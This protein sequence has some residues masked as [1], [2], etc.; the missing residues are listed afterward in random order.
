MLGKS[1]W[2][3]SPDYTDDSVQTFK[4]DFKAPDMK[5]ATLYISAMGV[6]APYLNG[7]RVGRNV[8]A[9]G[10]TS[11]KKRVQ[12]QQYDVTDMLKGENILEIGVGVGWTSGMGWVGKHFYRERPAVIAY[13]EMTDT[14]G[15]M[16]TLCTD[17]SWQVWAGNVIQSTIYHG[18]TVDMT[19][20]PKFLC[21]AEETEVASALVAQTGED[22]TEHERIYPVEVIHTPKGELV[23]DFGQNMTGYVEMKI[24]GE[25]GTK[26]V[27]HHAEV[28]DRD[29]NFYTGNYRHAKNENIYILS[30]N[31][32]VFKPTYTFQGFRY[33]RLTG[34]PHEKVNTMDF[35]AIA[36]HSE[37]KR[38]GY[39]KCGNEKINQ[40]YHNI[41]WGH[42]S[43]YLDVPTDCP[44]RDERLG[45]TCDTHVFC[46]T[47][48]I[49]YDVQKFLTKWMED[50]AL[51]QLENG[52]IR[53]IVP[54]CLTADQSRPQCPISG[55][56]GD[57][58]CIVPW[59]M[60]L[61]Y[62]DKN[63]LRQFLPAMKKWV[64]YEHSTDPE[65]FLYLGG[66]HY[67]DWLA[68]DHDP[69][70]LHGATS[71]DLLA[72]AYFA[73]STSLVVKAG[74]IIGEDVEEYKQL[75]KKVVAKFRE[76]FME[77]GMPK[78]SFPHT[79]TAVPPRDIARK[80]VTQ[81]ALTLILRFN[82]CTDEER[83]ALVKKLVELIHDFG[84]M[85]STGFV[86]TPHILHALSENG[87]TGL[88]YTLFFNEK[89]PSWLYSV[90]HGATTMW[91]H[92]NSLKEDGTFWSDS[93]NSFNHY[94][95]GAV[96]DWIFGVV[97]G[98]KP[99]EEKPGYEEITLCPHPDKRLGF[100][101]TL[102][103]SRRG[104]IK[105][106]WYYKGDVVYYEFD[107]PQGVTARL[108]LPSGY[109]QTLNGGTY[110]F[111]E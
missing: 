95:Y 54:E 83:P 44:Q 94:A 4:K 40:L 103:K 92:W 89:N 5:K 39:F 65:E 111:A 26:I 22:I 35:C 19:A 15:N 86:G 10:W 60:Y 16:H 71:N 106:H 68:M 107:I 29:G 82:L 3:Q 51:E 67:G 48:A 101:Q 28:L 18:E 70:S 88:A 72:S 34:Y 73:Y 110:H 80:G 11:Y 77:N 9:P 25:R 63:I 87:H 59:E 69:D 1:K 27:M 62:G 74:K 20:K 75:Y 81:T 66:H 98:I 46:R 79:E 6:Y 93:M 13:L 37:M 97:M 99:I 2:I 96:F 8:L 33:I 30:G 43:N 23:I 50:L 78:E 105:V 102:F 58:A 90:C 108:T 55:I 7:K 32:D 109:T 31:D 56:W 14:D 45:W 17:S 57:A 100:A 76:Y 42:K 47:A 36:V 21:N 84:D 41:I 24:K 61:A 38:T 52:A 49:N 104:D 91:E 64:D 85:M 53:A 12:Y